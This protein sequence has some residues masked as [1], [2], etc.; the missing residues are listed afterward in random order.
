MNKEQAKDKL[1]KVLESQ[2]IDLTMMSKIELG[3]DVI[4]EIGKLKDTI[5]ISDWDVTLMDGLEN[6]PPYVSDDF[7]I[8]PN[9]AYEHTEELCKIK[10]MS[11][12]TIEFDRVEEAEELRAALDGHKYKSIIWELDQKLR[13]VCRYGTAIEGNK[14]ATE[15]EMNVCENLREI[16]REL[17]QEYN[18]PIE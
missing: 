14:E 8:G 18:L 4:T 3:N 1:I 15:E 12:V 10:N 13:S 6:E 16:I 17:L 2:V 5:A 11:K 7:Q 9:G